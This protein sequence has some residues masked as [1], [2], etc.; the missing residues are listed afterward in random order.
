M[1]TLGP[2]VRMLYDDILV[3]QLLRAYGTKTTA[4]VTEEHALIQTSH[5]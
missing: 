2:P 3:L 5:V 1:E 4:V